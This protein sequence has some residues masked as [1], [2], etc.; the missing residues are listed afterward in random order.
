MNNAE[1]RGARPPRAEN[2]SSLRQLLRICRTARAIRFANNFIVIISMT[3]M[4]IASK[5]LLRNSLTI[6]FRRRIFHLLKGGL[7]N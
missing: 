5:K 3:R 2:G 6:S 4:K 7:K 1:E